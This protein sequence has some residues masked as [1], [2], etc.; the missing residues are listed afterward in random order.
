MGYGQA[1]DPMD[2]LRALDLRDVADGEEDRRLGEAMHHHM[3][4]PGKIGERAAHS[5][6]KDDDAHVF[7]RGVGEQAFDVAPAV[8]HERREHQRDEAHRHHQ[9][10]GS[11]RGRV[12]RHQYLEAQQRI[13]RHVQQQA[14]QHRRY[15]GR[16]FGMGVGQ[17]GVQRREADLGPVAEKQEYEGDIEQGR[18]ELVGMFDQ[19]RPHHAVLAFAHDRTRRHVDEDGAEQGKRNSDAAENE[20]FPRGFERRV[21]AVNADHQHGGQRGDLDR[22]PHQADIVRHESEVHAEH[23]GLIHG[24]V[25]A[26][27]RRR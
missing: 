24:V 26:Q 27:V 3:Q 14:R 17:P 5:E 6:R 10:A 21:G 7:D 12:G 25:E 22:D 4:Q 23:H 18:V 1:P 19:Q 11:D 15:R 20:V 8:E 13:E 9:R 16:A 2:P